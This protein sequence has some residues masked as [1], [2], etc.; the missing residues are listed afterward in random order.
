M[1][2]YKLATYQS[3]DGPRAGIVIDDLVFDAAGLTRNKA[4][5]D[6]LAIL[7]DW[8]KAKGR[9]KA[10]AAA[11]AKRPAKGIALKKIKLLSPVP[12]PGAIYCAGA[13]YSDHAAEMARNQGRDPEP[14]P[15][16]LGLKSWHFV[17]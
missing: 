7:Q 15:H 13:N 16:T 6:M 10:A 2:G 3:K 11:A 12:L 17:K 5:G 9:L 14:D 1:A 8:G 4:D